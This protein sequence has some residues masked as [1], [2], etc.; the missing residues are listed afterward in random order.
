MM[1][2]KAMSDSALIPLGPAEP[3]EPVPIQE[4]HAPQPLVQIGLLH[5]TR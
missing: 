4:P 5:A 1:Q 3:I 2:I